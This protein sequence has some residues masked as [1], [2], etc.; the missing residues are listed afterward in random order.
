MMLI[1][2]DILLWVDLVIDDLCYDG[3]FVF[4]EEIVCEM[5][6][7]GMLV[8]FFYVFFVMMKDVLCVMEV[9]IMFFYFFVLV[10]VNYFCNVFDDVLELV[11]EN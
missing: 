1:Y 9:F 10:V 3:L 11:K 4:G 6:C 8:D 5:N 7:F 2:F